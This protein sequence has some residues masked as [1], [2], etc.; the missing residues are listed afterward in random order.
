VGAGPGSE[1]GRWPF[2]VKCAERRRK[3]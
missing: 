3:L 2:A 1:L